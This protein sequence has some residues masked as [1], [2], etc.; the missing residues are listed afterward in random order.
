MSAKNNG[1]LKV[2]NTRLS[3]I[4]TVQ[5]SI[6]E[7]EKLLVDNFIGS[8]DW[9]RIYHAW[10]QEVDSFGIDIANFFIEVKSEYVDSTTA[11]NYHLLCPRPLVAERVAEL[12]GK[13]ANGQR[14]H[15]TE[16]L[17]LRAGE[18]S[19][20]NYLAETRHEQEQIAALLMCASLRS[21]IHRYPEQWPQPVVLEGL[22]QLISQ[23]WNLGAQGYGWH[24]S[25]TSV[26]PIE[27]RDFDYTIDSL[28]GLIRY[29]STEHCK[30]L[31][32]YNLVMFTPKSSHD[33]SAIEKI[34]G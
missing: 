7:R 25:C 28:Q 27:T 30:L 2:T 29:M 33:K 31:T 4:K 22:Y 8:A 32:K 10:C 26:I 34:Y 20:I 18:L 3:K 17:N 24:S 9:E 12:Q 14:I 6:E 21:R 13:L 1:L 11:N 15:L 23:H 16:M 19:T 5:L